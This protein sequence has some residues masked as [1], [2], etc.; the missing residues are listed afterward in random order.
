[1]A[2]RYTPAPSSL[3][4]KNRAKLR[5]MLPE[6]SIVIVHSNDVMPTNAD[7]TL[8][9]KQNADFYYLSG[10]DQ[11]ESVLILCPDAANEADRE[12][13][14]VR[15][16]NEH[17]AIWEGDKLTKE[18]ATLASGIQ[19]VG[20]TSAFEGKLNQLMAESEN[21]YL[22]TN[23]HIR[24]E[25]SVETRNDR[26][27]AQCQKNFPLHQYRRLSPLLTRLRMVKEGEELAVI[28]EACEITKRGFDRVLAAVKPGIKEVEVEAEWAYEFVRSG[29]SFA[30]QPIV[31]TGA[32]ACVLHYLESAAVCREGDLLLMDCGASFGPYTSD[33]T[34]T[35]P[36]SGKF[37][38]RQRAV[39]DAVLRV[40]ERCVEILRP[41]ILLKDYQEQVL[42]LMEK[43]LIGLGLFTQE[44]VD[45]QEAPFTLV[46][47]Y[48]MHGTSHH[49][50]L[51]VHDVNVPG[52]PVE[53]GNVFTI[54]P[55]VYIREENIGIRLENTYYVGADATVNLMPEMPIA[56]DDIEAAMAK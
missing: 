4:T 52:V 10:V 8:P 45:A 40:L 37:T 22:V 3:F 6:N 51:D 24:A 50:G 55:G 34:R 53:V 18:Q 30:Y 7:G 32:N 46:R 47:K 23:E 29:G 1:M 35:I 48:F 12:W 43:E 54:E 5:E 38:E 13:L 49:L 9:F 14:F 28:K 19:S 25:G 33:S 16:T 20:W 27:I 36:V 15:E 31:A 26:F 17:I 2:Y 42:G 44:D 21:V 41:G 39:Y 56:A 11:E